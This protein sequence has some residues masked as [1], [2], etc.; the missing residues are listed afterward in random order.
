[1]KQASTLK[2]M[3]KNCVTAYL[4]TLEQTAPCNLYSMVICEVECALLETIMAH[5]NNNQTVAAQA[6]GISRGT[7]RKKLREHE[8][9]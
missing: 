6:L 1:M 5:S 2:V 9:L 7:L 4:E 8:L 3:T